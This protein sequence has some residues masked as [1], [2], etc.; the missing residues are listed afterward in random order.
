MMTR[1]IETE[2]II[3]SMIVKISPAAIRVEYQLETYIN[4]MV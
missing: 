4:A 2:F 1:M 3:K